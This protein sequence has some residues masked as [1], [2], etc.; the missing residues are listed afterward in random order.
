MTILRTLAAA[1]DARVL[2]ATRIARMFAY[3]LI[4]V[5]LALHLSALGFGNA[6]VGVLLTAVMLGDAGLSLLI[7]AIADRAG[8]RRMLGLGAVLMLAGG[9]VFAV[10]H[11]PILLLAGAIIG[12]ISPSGYEVGPFQAIEQAALSQVVSREER[13]SVFAWYGLA[14]SLATACGSLAGGYAADLLQRHGWTVLGSY[15]SVMLLY[16]LIGAALA[17]LFLSASPRIEAPPDAA[18]VR[19]RLFGL[20][21]SRGAVFK[22]SALFGI[23]AFAGGFVVQSILALWFHLRFGVDPAALGAIFFDANILSGVSALAAAGFARRIGLVNTMVFTHL[24]S[25]VLLMLVPLMPTLPLAVAVLLVRFSISQMDVPTRQAFT[26]ALVDPDERSAAA[27]VTGVARSLA[28][29]LS[30]ALAGVMLSGA[31]LFSAPFYLGGGLKVLYDL[32]VYRLFASV[33]LESER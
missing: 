14:G 33:D 30:P 20:H 7:T 12:V 13:V 16:A 24:P 21:R 18:P 6:L 9:L 17:V 8:R 25:N 26:M 29:A 27:G 28:S 23:D 10:S 5:V 32:L 19:P 22:L 4:A 15:Q 2:F 1:P 11:N 31:A 3:G